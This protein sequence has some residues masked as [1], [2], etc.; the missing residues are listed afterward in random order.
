MEHLLTFYGTVGEMLAWSMEAG[1]KKNLHLGSIDE[2]QKKQWP[3]MPEAFGSNPDLT[4]LDKLP[5][6]SAS[7]SPHLQNSNHNSTHQRAVM[8]IK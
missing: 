8:S 2:L 1:A 5:H 6:L 3:L 4:I 7:H